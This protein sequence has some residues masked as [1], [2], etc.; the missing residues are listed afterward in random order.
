MNYSN[1]PRP[2]DFVKDV[3]TSANLFMLF[4]RV[5]A[6][7]LEVFLHYGM[8]RRY[9]GWNAIGVFALV[10]VYGLFWPRHDLGP[11]ALFLAAYLFMVFVTRASM[12]SV[13]PLDRHSY[14]NGF[15]RFL[16]KKKAGH[17]AHFKGCHEPMFVFFLG[18]GISIPNPPLGCF[19]M[20]GALC[21]LL[22]GAVSQALHDSQSMDINDALIEQS[23]LTNQFRSRTKR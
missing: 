1:E 2:R 8:G 22:Q 16:R 19:L 11:L 17:E 12:F 15:P 14:Y 23:H 7:S 10:P 20:I 13:G 21:L 6:T 4:V 5:W 18:G 9:L 3:E